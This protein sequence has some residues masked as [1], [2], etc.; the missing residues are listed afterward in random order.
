MV[1]LKIVTTI[2]KREKIMD[3]IQNNYVL[4]RTSHQH[5]IML[6]P[7]SYKYT[8]Q[9]IYVKIFWFSFVSFNI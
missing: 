9:Q 7:T 8:S 4:S 1:S 5:N 3:Y 2:Q 6:S